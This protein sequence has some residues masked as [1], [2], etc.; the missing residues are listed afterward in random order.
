MARPKVHPDNRL[1]A[2]TACTA[3]RKSKKRC[4]GQFPC[5]N[6]LHKGLGGSCIPF[7]SLP[8]RSRPT[9]S[10]PAA[11][12]WSEPEI[13]LQSPLR[14]QTHEVVTPNQRVTTPEAESHSPEA[15]HRTH[16]RMLRNRQ[17][18]RVYVGKA[19]SLSFLQLLRDTVTQHIGPSQ[20]SQ[21]SEDMLETEAHHAQLNFSTELCHA[22]EKRQFIQNYEAAV[23]QVST[24]QSIAGMLTYCKTSGFFDLAC[25]ADLFTSLSNQGEP[26]SDR[27]KT[28]TAIV[29][30]M[31]AIGAQTLPNSPESLQTE[32]FYVARG[33]QRA[34]SNFLEDPSMDLVRVFLLLS[35]Y[36]LGACRRNAAFMYLGVASRAAVALGLHERTPGSTSRDDNDQRP[37]LWTSLCVLDLLVSA[38]LGR[39]SATSPLL[40]GHPEEPIWVETTQTESGLVAS[41]HLSL[42]LDEIISSLYGEKTASAETADVLLGKLNNWSEC[43]PH[44]LRTSSLENES[45][46]IA[47]KHTLGN[48]HVAC[49]YHFAVILVTRPF[50]ISALSVRLAQSHHNLSATG[51]REAPEED[52][53]HSRLA[54][55]CIDSAV[56]M[57]QTCIEVY[58]SGLM[59]RNM[60]ILK[61]FIFAAALVLGFS[62]FAHRDI[63][64]DIDEA[65]RGAM[66]ILRMLAPQSAQAAHYLDITI[67]L[68]SAIN[69]QRQQLAAQARQRRSQYVSRI[70][71]LN[72]N[73]TT[74]QRQSEAHEQ[75]SGTTPLLTQS[76]P[77]YSWLQSDD[78]IGTVTPPMIDGTLFDWEGMDLPLWD[79]F[80]FL[81]ESAVI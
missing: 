6:C 47:Q 23:R 3:C 29:D 60:C 58:D 15:P 9:A 30:L 78:G 66:T 8:A 61:A 36:M 19:A 69:Q 46:S 10:R 2:N 81:T 74:P 54:A 27:E 26:K 34:F 70:F 31:V 67:M 20:F 32:R 77:S 33:Q 28:R 22:D 38:I 49:S 24:R 17:G 75:A 44:S 14:S 4:S 12:R 11:P 73:P 45:E 43:L 53:V 51:P 13:G 68:E 62:M 42:I 52:P 37:K 50:L 48:M 76:I 80:P 1:R 35:F 41:Y 5:S 72:D 7:R 56:Y 64:S 18:D 40:S 16:P 59:L 25:K 71:S 57:L 79:S 39:P 65:F 55:A 63:D 21:R